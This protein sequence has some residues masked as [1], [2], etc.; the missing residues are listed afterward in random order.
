MRR[1]TR[2]NFVRD[3]G[4]TRDELACCCPI[5]RCWQ[6]M[7]YHKCNPRNIGWHYQTRRRKDGSLYFKN[8][9]YRWGHFKLYAEWRESYKAFYDWA[10]ANG[11]QR[12]LTIE[13][14]DSSRGYTPDNCRWATYHEQALH[15][16]RVRRE[17]AA[18]RRARQ[19]HC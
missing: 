16:A 14:I 3:F 18:R 13:R 17:N 10:I 11:W 1:K 9:C 2:N 12:G 19:R 4:R 8:A 5:F 7:V 15:A 6:N